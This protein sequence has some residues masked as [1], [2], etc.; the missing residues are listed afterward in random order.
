MNMNVHNL[1]FL[2]GHLPSDLLQAYNKKS[3]PW[4]KIDLVRLFD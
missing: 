3:V 1:I 4:D 2:Q